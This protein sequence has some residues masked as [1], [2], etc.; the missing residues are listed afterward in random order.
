MKEK[1]VEHAWD[2]FSLSQLTETLRAPCYSGHH[3]Y[4]EGI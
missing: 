2:N 1:E 4:A 3:D